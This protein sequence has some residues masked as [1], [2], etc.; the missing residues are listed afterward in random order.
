M[1]NDLQNALSDDQDVSGI[2]PLVIHI[3][4]GAWGLSSLSPFC[5]K[6]ETYLRM[7]DIPFRSIVGEPPNL[8]P[9]GKVPWL[10]YE[11]KQIG[12]SSLIIE[13]LEERFCLNSYE[14]LS[15]VDLAIAHALQRLIEE[16]LAWVLVY[17]RWVIESSE[18]Q[19]FRNIVLQSEPVQIRSKIAKLAQRSLKR[20][21]YAHG[22]GRHSNDEVYTIGRRDIEAIAQFLGERQFLL[23]NKP[24]I[25]DASAY[26]VLANI[27]KSP[28]ESALKDSVLKQ[29]NTVEYID[30]IQNR[31]FS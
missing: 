2:D 25:V 22:L 6:L 31:Y 11:G 4:H 12:D 19:A 13:F 14:S 15:N 16:N 21:L 7:V 9:K 30:R 27:I 5:L 10:E 1:T 28:W 24:T 18:R 23:G 26:C 8:G 20:Q 29:K 3:S 17:D